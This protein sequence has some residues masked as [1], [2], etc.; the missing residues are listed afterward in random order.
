M[1]DEYN[2]SESTPFSSEA[3]K[4]VCLS[5]PSLGIEVLPY[6]FELPDPSPVDLHVG[7]HSSTETKVDRIGSI[8][9]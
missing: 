3:S 8:D 7:V 2:F 4:E 6:C 9:W 1:D 5:G